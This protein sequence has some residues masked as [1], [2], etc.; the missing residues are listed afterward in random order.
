MMPEKNG[1][2]VCAFLKKE[3][4]TSHIPIILLTAK[5]DQSSK[6]TGLSKGADAYLHKPFNEK[7]LHIRI[8]ML[9]ELRLRLQAYHLAKVGFEGIPS[10]EQIAPSSNEEQFLVTVR[11]YIESQISN[12]DFRMTQLYREVGMSKTQFH[13][14]LRALVDLTPKQILLTIRMEKAKQLL[15][16]VDL[17]IN[18]IAHQIGFNDSS[19][20]S[21]TFKK[22]FGETPTLFR[23]KFQVT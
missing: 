6:L 8:R 4:R 14:K 18:E 19:H 9:L 3:L 20:F 5:V 1:Y 21:Q 15:C 12:P 16:H 22:H 13:H 7:E 17:T 2:Q 11:A 10:M 23:K